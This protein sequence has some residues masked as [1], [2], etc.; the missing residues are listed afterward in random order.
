MYK[1]CLQVSDATT[2]SAYELLY[3]HACVA[4]PCQSSQRLLDRPNLHDPLET[5]ESK[6]AY[7][8]EN[9]KEV[10]ALFSTLNQNACYPGLEDIIAGLGK[11]LLCFFYVL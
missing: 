10:A 1:N 4:V 5:T 6:K 9:A 3:Y 7:L 8:R 11:F 2:M